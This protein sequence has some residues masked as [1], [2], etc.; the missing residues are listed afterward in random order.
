MARHLS[1][2]FFFIAS[3]TLASCERDLPIQY[4]LCDVKT[5]K[6]HVTARFRDMKSCEFFKELGGIYCDR[7]TTPGLI[8]C[9]QKRR[10]QVTTSVCR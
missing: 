3:F 4:V 7:E 9:D 1:L 8:V 5:Q 2:F 6:C 10:S